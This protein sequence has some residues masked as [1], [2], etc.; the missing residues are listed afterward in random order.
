MN[1]AITLTTWKVHGWNTLLDHHL[2]QVFESPKGGYFQNRQPWRQCIW[3]LFGDQLVMYL[4]LQTTFLITVHDI[5]SI[6]IWIA[7]DVRSCP[8]R[9][10]SPVVSRSC[11]L[12]DLNALGLHK[13][14][15]SEITDKKT[16]SF[17]CS[18][19][20]FCEMEVL[21]RKKQKTLV[22]I[23]GGLHEVAFPF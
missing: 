5:L 8:L 4:Q 23:R 3:S 6:Q 12:G 1:K 20:F 7:F 14:P 16:F 13:N 22:T 18:S 19:V 21:K 9:Y 2:M 15:A 11:S 17:S 10:R